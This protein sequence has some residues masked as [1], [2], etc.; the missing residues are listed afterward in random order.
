MFFQ[1]TVKLEMTE[2]RKE[3]ADE[4]SIIS[5]VSR[6][7]VFRANGFMSYEMMTL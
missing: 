6:L 7:E 1:F 4:L 2:Q 3:T 5:A